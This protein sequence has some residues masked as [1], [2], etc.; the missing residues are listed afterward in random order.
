MCVLARC[1]LGSACSRP[2]S[3]LDLVVLVWCCHVSCSCD[4]GLVMSKSIIKGETQLTDDLAPYEGG[5]AYGLI[6]RPIVWKA[7]EYGVYMDFGACCR[8]RQQQSLPILPCLWG[9]GGVVFF[10]A[11]NCWSPFSTGSGS[12]S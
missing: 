2:E 3:Q 11:T 10:G 7:R 12:G 9:G 1:D 6:V 5:D 4:A 8:R